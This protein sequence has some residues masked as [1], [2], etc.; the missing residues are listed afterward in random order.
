MTVL[1]HNKLLNIYI[2][3]EF[4]QSLLLSSLY[5]VHQCEE[6]NDQLG[7]KTRDLIR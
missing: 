5:K 4:Q 3:N 6:N 7:A 2:E 1:N